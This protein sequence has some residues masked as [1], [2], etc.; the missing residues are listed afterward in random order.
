MTVTVAFDPRPATQIDPPSK[1]ALPYRKTVSKW[2]RRRLNEQ[3]KSTLGEISTRTYSYSPATY[4][5]TGT[6]SQQVYTT[7]SKDDKGRKWGTSKQFVDGDPE[8]H[9]ERTAGANGGTVT[10]YTPCTVLD[11][12]CPTDHMDLNDKVVRL[13]KDKR[14]VQVV[15]LPD[16][17]EGSDPTPSSPSSPPAGSSRVLASVGTA[18]SVGPAT[19]I[20]P[21]TALARSV[22]GDVDTVLAEWEAHRV[23]RA[24]GIRR[25]GEARTRDGVRARL[26]RCLTPRFSS[27]EDWLTDYAGL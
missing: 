5:R 26:A 7:W 21:V 6:G 23:A 18:P 24:E 13:G 10:S 3:G 20:E 22:A 11:G 1:Y 15:N 8:Y 14:P 27:R 12:S 9:V 25:A 4:K 2:E 16:P 19:D 17:T